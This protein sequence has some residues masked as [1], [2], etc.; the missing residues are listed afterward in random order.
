MT[1]SKIPILRAKICD[2]STKNTVDAVKRF[3]NDKNY[4]DSD[5]KCAKTV[6]NAT[7]K[8]E[9]FLPQRTHFFE[10]RKKATMAENFFRPIPPPEADRAA[11]ICPK[12]NASMN[13]EDFLSA[14]LAEKGTSRPI[15]ERG[16]V[17][18]RAKAFEQKIQVKILF[19]TSSVGSLNCPQIGHK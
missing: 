17:R 8:A 1:T 4:V 14:F 2:S 15:V 19:S 9:T 18:A 5:K 16:L 6:D 3:D 13:T 7:A 12:P 10:G 11:K